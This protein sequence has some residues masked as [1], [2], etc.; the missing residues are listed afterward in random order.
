M[1]LKDL[2]QQVTD[3]W[4]A[5]TVAAILRKLDSYPIRWN[6]T[7]R[8]S[9]S[10]EQ[11]GTD[12][13]FNMADYGSFIDEGVS[14]TVVKRDTPFSFRGRYKGTA[15]Y[16]KDWALS[17]GLNQWAVAKSIQKK[18]IKP[19]P[20]FTSVIESRIPELEPFIAQATED[21]LIS[22]LQQQTSS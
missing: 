9:I 4:G 12:I 6:G 11:D 22:V 20:F 21:Y 17:K 5:E 7:L 19:R 2:L 1:E 8:R 14:G 15:F 16:I 3:Q 10:Y 13:R 18:G